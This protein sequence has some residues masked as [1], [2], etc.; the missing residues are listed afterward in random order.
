MASLVSPGNR[1][2][3]VGCDHAHT[4]IYL[5]QAGISPRVLAMDLRKGPL[6]K[7]R[8]NVLEAG[9]E[10]KIELR[11]SDG[12]DALGEGEADTM[13]ISGMGGPL[14]LEILERNPDKAKSV[15]ELVLSPQSDLP[16]FQKGLEAMGF[17]VTDIR[18]VKDDKFYF[19]FK[20]VP[21]QSEAP[22]APAPAPAEVWLEYL[23]DEKKNKEKILKMLKRDDGEK[24]AARRDELYNE[25][26][27]I[28]DEIN[29]M[30]N[31]KGI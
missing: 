21:A 17:T 12:L 15:K 26:R 22:T 7:A 28:E 16:E 13:I 31:R 20:A 14:I 5:V 30:R 1:T 3:D 18:I 29:R 8:E 24:A 9:L 6:E 11:L 27:R 10:E 19:V 2:A 25:I 4:G 23:E